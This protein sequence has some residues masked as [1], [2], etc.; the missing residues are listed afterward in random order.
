MQYVYWF[1][2]KG[3]SKT[4]WLQVN[5]KKK[6]I[7]NFDTVIIFCYTM[8]K[9]FR[10]AIT[11]YYKLLR[12]ILWH[13]KTHGHKICHTLYPFRLLNKTMGRPGLVGARGKLGQGPI[14]HIFSKKC[15]PN[16]CWR[17]AKTLFTCKRRLDAFQIERRFLSTLVC[18][19]VP[20]V[21][22]FSCKSSIITF[23]IM[24]T[25]QILCTRENW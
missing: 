7:Q 14:F 25:V 15:Q 3:R 11:I 22:F 4:N 18:F 21:I 17:F 6:C 23:W 2:H 5:I 16:H 24:G 1:Y 19:Q 13:L 20:Q 8:V 12:Y 10:T 9:S